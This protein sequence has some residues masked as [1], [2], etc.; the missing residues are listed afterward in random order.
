[1]A[2][3]QY[4]EQQQH[5][6]D[7][8]P[9][10]EQPNFATSGMLA[11]VANTVV[12]RDRAAPN[13][14]RAVVRKYHEPSEAAIATRP[15]TLVVFD[16]KADDKA[17]PDIMD[18]KAK[19]AYMFGRDDQLADVFLTHSHASSQHA[20]LQFRK[21]SRLTAPHQKK[22]RPYLIDLESTNGSY[23]NKS[24]VGPARY[25]ELKPKDV[26]TFGPGSREYVIMCSD[27]L[28]S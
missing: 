20:V 18:L 11:R 8:P 15:W 3:D 27:A 25:V 2:D 16:P 17:A 14:A 1:M 22:I 21:V 5:D 28:D 24:K 12:V 7:G 26:F 19:S 4:A 10:V 13:G 23:L 9:P 6:D